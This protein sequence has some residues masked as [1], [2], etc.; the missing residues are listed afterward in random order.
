MLLALAGMLK[1][2]ELP[3]SELLFVRWLSACRTGEEL[4]GGMQAAA[5]VS[6][7]A[8]HA[9]PRGMLNKG[10][11]HALPALDDLSC[12]CILLQA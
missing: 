11:F 4:L 10:L 5:V 2:L 12:L 3:S 9:K 8:A 1:Y 7:S 6:W